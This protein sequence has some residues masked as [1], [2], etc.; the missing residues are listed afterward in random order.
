MQKYRHLSEK[1]E[2]KI[3]ILKKSRKIAK[4]GV[5]RSLIIC[6]LLFVL[7]IG[8]VSFYK[9]IDNGD[10]SQASA[11][12]DVLTDSKEKNDDETELSPLDQKELERE[13]AKTDTIKTETENDNEDISETVGTECGDFAGWNKGCSPEMIVVNKDN[14]LP[15]GYQPRIKSCRGR[16]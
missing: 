8:A 11:A 1:D 7:G 12:C 13:S 4:K 10:S 6:G 16:I 14:S 5:K 2:K 15:K 3:K 9:V